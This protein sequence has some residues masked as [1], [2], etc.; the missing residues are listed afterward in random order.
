MLEIRAEIGEDRPA[1]YEVNKLAFGQEKEPRLVD[2][3]RESDDFISELSLVAVKEGKVV[4]HILFNPM[5]IETKIG[6]VR[7]LG[8]APLAVLPEFQRH[9]IGSELVRKGLEECQHFGHEVV[10]VIGHPEYYPRFGFSSARA[11]GLE[12]PFEVPDEAFM[13]LE[14]KE[15]A[16][17]GI[18]GTIKLPPAFEGL[19]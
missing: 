3:L 13:V 6:L 19:V 2:A 4:G 12:A 16:L 5:V 18:S 9:G 7:V 11:K 15:G 1:I 10:V 17:E 14:I 8:L